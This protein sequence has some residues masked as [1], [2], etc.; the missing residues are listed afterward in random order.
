MT[1]KI[2]S[3]YTLYLNIL[4]NTLYFYYYF[5]QICKI[6][7]AISVALAKISSS[8]IVMNTFS[9]TFELV[10]TIL[11]K[12]EFL[13]LSWDVQNVCTVVKRDILFKVSSVN[14][15]KKKLIY[16][17]LFKKNFLQP[18][19][20]VPGSSA[21][22][23]GDERYTIVLEGKYLAELEFPEGRR[24]YKP[25]KCSLGGVGRYFSVN[26]LLQTT[27]GMASSHECDRKSANE[28]K[29]SHV[30]VTYYERPH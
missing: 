29:S 8:C 24:G 30:F 25:K 15:K 26:K 21:G 6:S 23:G 12:S 28:T 2:L 14:T 17:I 3:I 9:N 4:L 27:S 16:Y 1:F 10:G 22:G 11:K 18:I 20:K 13:R 5:Q 19:G 7:L